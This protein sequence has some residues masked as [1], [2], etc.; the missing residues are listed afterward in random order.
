M[1]NGAFDFRFQFALVVNFPFR[2]G[3]FHRD[4]REK[5]V[6]AKFRVD[7]AFLKRRGC[8]LVVV[9]DVKEL[10]RVECCF[11]VFAVL[12][13]RPR[14][15]GGRDVRIEASVST[16]SN[17][18]SVV[19]TQCVCATFLAERPKQRRQCNRKT[20]RDVVLFELI[21]KI[22]SNVFVVLI[23]L[24]RGATPTFDVALALS[25][26]FHIFTIPLPKQDILLARSYVQSAH[27]RTN[28]VHVHGD[29][30]RFWRVRAIS[31]ASIGA[32]RFE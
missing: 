10:V 9:R 15:D 17:V 18:A 28:C 2:V 26:L 19:I 5:T 13:A 8:F 1:N 16:G 6:D 4:V 3:W 29:R 21:L 7:D 30:L 32:F 23:V 22:F 27:E 14:R 24:L 25:R 20:S 12:I 31:R 11:A